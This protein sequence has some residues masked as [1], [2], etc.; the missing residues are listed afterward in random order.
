M[1]LAFVCGLALNPLAHLI[2]SF[3]IG[4]TSSIAYCNAPI[5]MILLGMYLGKIKAIEVFKDGK[6]YMVCLFRLIVIPILSI[7]AFWLVPAEMAAMRLGLLIAA[8]TPVGSN[9]AV[10]AQK[11]GKDYKFAVVVTCL[12]TLISTITI[13]AMVELALLIWN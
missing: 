11:Y 7:L 2:P 3:I 1:V 13:P 8:V 12:S 6:A 9:I 10:Y 5:A 4:C